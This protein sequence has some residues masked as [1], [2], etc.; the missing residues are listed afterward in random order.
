MEL[1]K[2]LYE[3]HSPSGNEKKLKQFIKK[4]VASN[5]EGVECTWDNAGNVYFTKGESETYPVVVA[6]LDQVQKSHAK[7]FKQ[8]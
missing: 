3:I 8:S 7:D 6:H 5:I 2:A 4:W 1:L